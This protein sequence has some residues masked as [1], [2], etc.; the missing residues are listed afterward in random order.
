MADVKHRCC[1]DFDKAKQPGTDNEEY[2]SLIY[3]DV[4]DGKTKIGAK[5]PPIRFCP[6]C[7][8]EISQ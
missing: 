7:G 3:V 1:S 2:D 5:L 4:D 8:A 6:W